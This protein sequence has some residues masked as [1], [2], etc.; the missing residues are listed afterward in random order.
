MEITIGSQKYG[1]LIAGILP[2][3]NSGG[4]EEDQIPAEF[5]VSDP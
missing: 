3:N 1:T 5:K 4:T 2:S